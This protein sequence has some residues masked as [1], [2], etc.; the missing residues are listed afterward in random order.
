MCP[1]NWQKPT[2][3]FKTQKKVYISE[4]RYRGGDFWNYN[5]QIQE[6]FISKCEKYILL[7]YK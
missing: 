1:K 2:I 3:L 7:P 4:E 5:R 6:N